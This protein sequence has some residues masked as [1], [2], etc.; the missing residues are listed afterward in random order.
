MLKVDHTQSNGKGLKMKSSDMV[1][2]LEQL[3]EE[4]KDLIAITDEYI[5]VYWHQDKAY[6]A[7]KYWHT[8]KHYAFVYGSYLPLHSDFVPGGVVSKN[9]AIL[10]FAKR[11]NK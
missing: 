7:W 10:W 6:V 5:L 1:V 9:E 11:I 8:G 2:L 3:E 4:G